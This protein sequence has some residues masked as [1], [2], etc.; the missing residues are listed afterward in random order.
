MISLK[1]GWHEVIWPLKIFMIILALPNPIMADQIIP[2][3]FPSR[4]SFLLLFLLVPKTPEALRGPKV[5]PQC[6]EM[7]QNGTKTHTEKAYLKRERSRPEPY[8]GPCGAPLT[9]ALRPSLSPPAMV[10]LPLTLSPPSFQNSSVHSLF[11]FKKK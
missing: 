4:Y 8:S 6:V 11:N 3:I 5:E 10:Q 7:R 1:F 9:L 2:S